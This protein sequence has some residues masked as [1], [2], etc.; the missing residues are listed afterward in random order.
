VSTDWACGYN[1]KTIIIPGGKLLAKVYFKTQNTQN[2]LHE[3]ML[4]GE[5]CDYYTRMEPV[6]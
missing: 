1:G 6:G 5:S 3:D 4:W 2:I